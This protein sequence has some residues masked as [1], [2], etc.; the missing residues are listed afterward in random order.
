LNLGIAGGG[1]APK[2]QSIRTPLA[3]TSLEKENSRIEKFHQLMESDSIELGWLP[4][5]QL[6]QVC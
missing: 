3:N 1:C 4:V 2:A 5:Y 6:L